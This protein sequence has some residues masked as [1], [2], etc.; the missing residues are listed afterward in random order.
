MWKISII[1]TV[2]TRLE[3]SNYCIKY[4]ENKTKLTNLHKSG[5]DLRAD[6]VIKFEAFS[7]S[8][9]QSHALWINAT[10]QHEESTNSTKSNYRK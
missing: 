4:Q 1:H 2:S 3:S 6:E 8:L 10:F 5:E 7:T 9:R